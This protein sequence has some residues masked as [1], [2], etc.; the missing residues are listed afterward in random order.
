MARTPNLDATV[1]KS[2]QR[3]FNVKQ[4]LAIPVICKAFV[5]FSYAARPFPA[6]AECRFRTD[7]VFSVV[8]PSARLPRGPLAP[9]A[10]VSSVFYSQESGLGTDDA[11]QRSSST[12]EDPPP[13]AG[14]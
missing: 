3:S 1:D 11:G 14:L 5:G 7:F 4:K 6:A 13:V 10:R 12:R 8:L 9:D 2:R